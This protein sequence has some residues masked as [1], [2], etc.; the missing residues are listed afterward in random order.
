MP[1]FPHL[2]LW[3]KDF[4]DY[5]MSTF[6]GTGRPRGDKD[7]LLK[8]PIPVPTLSEQRALIDGFNRLTDEINSKRQQ[9]A[10]L[11][12]SVKSRFVKIVGSSAPQIPLKNL[13]SSEP[14]N[15][16]Y[17]PQSSYRRDG[18]GTPI[19]RID[20]F[21]SGE[22]PHWTLLK[23][24]ECTTSEV[25]TYRLRSG[26]LLINRVNSLPYLGKVAYIDEAIAG[27][28]FESN[29]MRFS[30]SNQAEPRYV[31]YALSRDDVHV[32]IEQRAKL[33]VHQASINQ[34]DVSQLLIPL[35][36][37]SLQQEF[38]DFAAEAD[39]SQFALEQEVDALSAERDALLDRFLA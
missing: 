6:T 21:I 3:Q 38:A 14:Q 11:K 23:R 13:F 34:A 36:P 15:G 26:D 7:E 28:V 4:F 5:D 18:T 27:A 16:L 19:V 25:L 30:I 33:A 29:L 32:Q 2:L 31:A 8:Y 10:A 24:L 37:L 20:S 1:E 9:I 17:K 22:T 39:K 12:E 35:P